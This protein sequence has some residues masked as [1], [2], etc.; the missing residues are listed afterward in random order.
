[1]WAEVPAK[2]HRVDALS[3]EDRLKKLDSRE[4]RGI[5]FGDRPSGSGHQMG[6]ALRHPRIDVR[7]AAADEA[8]GVSSVLHE[9][10]VEYELLYKREAFAVTTP[11]ADELQSRW[12]AGPVWVAL[13]SHRVVGTRPSSQ[14]FST[15]SSE[16]DVILSRH[17]VLQCIVRAVRV[18]ILKDSTMERTCVGALLVKREEGFQILLGR[19][20]ATRAFYPNVWDVPGGHCEPGEGPE[21]TLIRE[22]REELGII[23]SAWRHFGDFQVPLHDRPDESIV[24]HLYEVS[25]WTGTPQN[26]APEEH[27][28]LSWFTIDDACRLTLADSNYVA[29]FRRLALTP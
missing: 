2:G 15:G 10:F 21:Q 19:R 3:A 9:A 13:Q 16:P 6:L 5:A 7:L 20:S 29:L 8:A 27:A 14:H 4:V 17:P 26:C 18:V 22:L 23:P 11:I 24:M 12:R 28:E 1:M 25:A